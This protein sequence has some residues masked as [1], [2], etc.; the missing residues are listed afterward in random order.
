MG[1]DQGDPP[2]RQW[3]GDPPKRRKPSRVGYSGYASIFLALGSVLAALGLVEGWI[4]LNTPGYGGVGPGVGFFGLVL[5][6]AAASLGLVVGVFWLAYFH[7]PGRTI[8]RVAAVLVALLGLFALLNWAPWL[9]RTYF[10]PEI[11]GVVASSDYTPDGVYHLK[12]ED[13]RTL[14][15]R[16]R[17]QQSGSLRSAGQY[18]PL[19][20]PGDIR[21]GDLLLAGHDPTSWYEVA[22]VWPGLGSCTDAAATCYS[23]EA[24]GIVRQDSIDLDTGLRLKKASTYPNYADVGHG[25]RATVWFNRLGEVT[26]VMGGP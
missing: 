8:G 5:L 18:A 21:P 9:Q 20:E 17:A 15:A 24:T 26:D 3:A 7:P 19:E 16:G 4:L 10:T 12:L 22:H 25:F 23:L 2:K 13:G 1:T 11:V 6:A 14:E